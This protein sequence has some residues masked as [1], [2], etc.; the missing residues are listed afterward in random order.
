LSC[1]IRFQKSYRGPEKLV[2]AAIGSY[3]VDT[4]GYSDSRATDQYHKR[5]DK[6]HV[7]DHYNGS[8]QIHTAGGAGMDI[9][10]VGHSVIHTPNHD[11]HPK[12]ILHVSKAT[13][14]FCSLVAS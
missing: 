8:D 2:S 12:N 10:H 13:K 4:N 7:R 9:R 14:V 1:W 3:G 5:T 11:L 6:H